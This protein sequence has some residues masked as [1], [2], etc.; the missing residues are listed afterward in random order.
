MKNLQKILSLAFVV[1]A[2]ATFTNCSGDDNDAAET[3]GNARVKISM[4]DA[5]GDFDAVFVEV[6][7][8]K[9]KSNNEPGEDG[10]ISVGNVTPRV[11]NLLDLTGGVTVML[12]DSQIPSGYLGQIRLILGNNN[13]VVIDGVTHELRTP[14]AQQSGLKLKIDQTLQPGIT[15][16][17]LIDFDVERS[18]VVAGNSGN[19][20]LHPVLRVIANAVSGSIEGKVV[21]AGFQSVVSVTVGN[22]IIS[23]YTNAEGFFVLYGLPQGTYDVMIKPDI[24]SGLPVRVIQNVAVTNGNTTDLGLLNL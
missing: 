20:N 9:I 4:T 22:E 24:L 21:N 15:Y 1:L 11:Y 18:I 8:V 23:S 6:I 13:S 14:S 3:A 7:D 2:M 5:P 17:F 10:W 12:A 19:I 16:N